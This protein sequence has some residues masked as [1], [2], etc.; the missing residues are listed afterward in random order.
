MLWADGPPHR[1]TEPMSAS[2]PVSQGRRVLGATWIVAALPTAIVAFFLLVL[3]EQPD[4]RTAGLVLAA[5][6]ASGAVLGG[7]LLTADRAPNTFVSW[8]L[9]AVWAVAALALYPTQEFVADAIWVS[10]VPLVAAVVT[11]LVAWRWPA[12]DRARTSL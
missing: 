4:D 3:S 5:L 7:L 11:A 1:H 10:G 9:S 2:L 8:V 6:A 12:S